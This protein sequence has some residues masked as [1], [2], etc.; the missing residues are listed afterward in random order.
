MGTKK[1]GRRKRDQE[2]I[3]CLVSDWPM[4]IHLRQDRKLLSSSSTQGRLHVYDTLLGISNYV[5]QQRQRATATAA[6]A[7][8]N[9]DCSDGGEE[10]QQ[11]RWCRRC[12]PGDRTRLSGARARAAATA[13]CSDVIPNRDED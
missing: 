9:S 10:E 11:Q 3:T 5:M 4:H 2:N 6:T 13:R 7:A 12:N 1:S 8:S